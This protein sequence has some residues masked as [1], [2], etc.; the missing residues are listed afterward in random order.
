MAVP[1]LPELLHAAARVAQLGS[2]PLREPSPQRP[3]FWAR[4]IVATKT[5][6]IAAGAAWADYL[7]L[8][9]G[10]DF[11]PSGYAASVTRFVATGK[12]NPAT[13]GLEYRFLQSGDLVRSQE[14]DLTP[15]VD[16]N[17]DRDSTT[18]F[19][20]QQ[21]RCSFMITKGQ[22][23]QLQVRNTGGASTLAYAG[24]FGWY[25]PA[26]V[27]NLRE[28]FEATGFAQDDSVRNPAG[29]M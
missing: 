1:T 25:F 16:L 28:A 2:I 26:S 27:G 23:L 3:P 22:V 21:R 13:S 4:P 12:D 9:G 29:G 15:G 8:R 7:V 20:S 11:F 17:V 6:P 14:F 24:L 10:F 5:R 19:P 18:P